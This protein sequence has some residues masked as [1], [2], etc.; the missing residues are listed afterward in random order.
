[1]VILFLQLAKMLSLGNT[2]IIPSTNP[3]ALYKKLE[4][5][6]LVFIPT[7]FN[8]SLI[9]SF[10]MVSIGSFAFYIIDKDLGIYLINAFNIC[11]S[12]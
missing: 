5:S 10:T 8:F 1:M 2:S 9:Y 4:T 12:S 3:R 6:K 7:F 11:I